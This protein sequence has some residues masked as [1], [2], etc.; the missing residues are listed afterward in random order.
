MTAFRRF[1]SGH[2]PLGEAFWLW[3]I[4]GGGVLNLFGTLFAVMLLTSGTPT[5][6]VVALIVLHI[7]LNLFL[8]VGVWRSAGGTGVSGNARVLARAGM[9]VWV[10]LLSLV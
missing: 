3:G 1:W 5:W 7:P 6:L 4:L 10:I 9:S 8:L 2:V